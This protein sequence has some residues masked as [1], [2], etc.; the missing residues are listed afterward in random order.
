MKTMLKFPKQREDYKR[1]SRR[2][3]QSKVR[4]AQRRQ[5]RSQ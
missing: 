4:R 3:S 1:S 2:K 5:K